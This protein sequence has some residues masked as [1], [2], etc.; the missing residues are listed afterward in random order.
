[1]ARVSRMGLP[2][3]S[4]SS[5]ANFSAFSSMRSATL[6]RMMARSALVVLPH[7]SK[8]FHAASTARST[9]SFVASA[10]VESFS[11]L[12]GQNTS[13]VPPSE[14]SVHSPPM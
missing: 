10:M 13:S 8:A 6:F 2:L 7:V 9:S 1:M 14:A 11:P 12:A 4:D 3:S 5:S